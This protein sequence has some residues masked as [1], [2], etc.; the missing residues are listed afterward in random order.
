MKEIGMH[1]EAVHACPDDHVIYYNQHE[2]ET[3]CMECHII[4]YRT[5]QVTKKVPCKVLR[6]IPHYSMFVTNFQVK[7]HSAIYGLPF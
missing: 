1:Y 7:K 4:R 6:Y 3:K 5:D 2:F